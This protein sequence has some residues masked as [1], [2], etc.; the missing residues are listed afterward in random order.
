MLREALTLDRL[1]AMATDEV[2]AWFVAQREEGLTAPEDA[3]LADW[4]AA[5]PAHGD[6]YRRAG[7]AWDA[8]ADAEGDEILAAMRAHA[9]APDGRRTGW[10]RMAAAAAVILVAAVGLVLQLGSGTAPSGGE[11]VRYI[12]QTEVREIALPD[13]S[14]MT[15]D[16][17]SAAVARFGGGERSLELERGRALFDVEPDPSRPFAVTAGTQR[18]VA[19]G[20]EFEVDRAPARLTVSLFHGKVAVERVSS[21]SAVTLMPGEQFVEANGVSVVRKLDT[22]AMPAGWRTGLL[23]F[24]DRPLSEAVAEVNRYASRPIVI[25]D[26]AVGGMRISGQF[27]AGDAERF[28]STVAEVHPL[29][30]VRREGEIELAP[31]Q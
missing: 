18:V 2:A 14:T 4:L 29:R 5:D 7:R 28:A 3:L 24:D 27:R 19:L 17:R 16:A 22:D 31:A 12:A 11:A 15:L 9:L 23:D 25:R 6:A 10:W 20:T 30:V 1:N 21:G 26:P 13:G 8:F